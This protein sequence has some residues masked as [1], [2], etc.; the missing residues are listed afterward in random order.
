M[1]KI[2]IELE[3]N[4]YSDRSLRHA[5]SDLVS[6][7]EYFCKRK[8]KL[9]TDDTT[10]FQNIFET[11]RFFKKYLGVDILARLEDEEILNLRR[12][13]NKRHA[14]MHEYGLITERYTRNIP[15]DKHLLHQK[16]V[17]SVEEFENG[18]R[19]FRIIHDNLLEAIDNK[20]EN[21]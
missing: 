11:K 13:F 3:N 1:Q 19:S 6:T 12:I 16:A 10:R 15:E 21:N 5:Y 8:A 9:L 20:S 18:V 17:L 4:D 14:Y 2:R 7:F